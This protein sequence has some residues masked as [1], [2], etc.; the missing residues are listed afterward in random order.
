MHPITKGH[1]QHTLAYAQSSKRRD[2]PASGGG[3]SP[4]TC[5]TCP[6]RVGQKCRLTLPPPGPPKSEFAA[7]QNPQ[8]ICKSLKV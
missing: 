3:P 2:L 7:S 6:P 5:N 8:V 1:P 4:N